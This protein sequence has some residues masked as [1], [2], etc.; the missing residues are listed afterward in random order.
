VPRARPPIASLD[1][2]LIASAGLEPA[3]IVGLAN[4]LAD[5]AR[6]ILSAHF[7]RP[8]AVEYKSDR[9]PVTA[10]DRLTEQTLRDR[11]RARFPAHAIAGEEHGFDGSDRRCVWVLDPIDGTKAFITGVPLFGSLIALLIDDRAV[12]G[13][14]EMPAL[15]ERWVGV[16]GRATEHDGE[17]CRTSARESLSSA[18][19]F[20]TSPSM[21]RGP[22]R[23]RFDA[24]S[25]RARMTRYGTDCYAYGLL[26]SGFVDLVVEADMKPYDY[27]ALVPVVEGAGGVIT[28]WRGDRLR[29]ESDG[30]VVAA[31]SATLHAEALALLA[32]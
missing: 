17:A 25:E 11:I 4:E 22:D 30:H 24:V 31:A 18:F 14:V 32:G 1:A 12:L 26:A 5:E 27:L 13:V 7:R 23:Q 9:S 3:A 6:S 10:V 19:L 16:C 28:D 2:S 8:A 21:F 20:A 15:A 29:F